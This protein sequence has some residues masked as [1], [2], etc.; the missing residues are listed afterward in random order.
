MEKGTKDVYGKILGHLEHDLLEILW[1]KGESN[2]KE[3]YAR[4]KD[5]R[6][7]ALTTVLTVLERLARKG[8]V[9]KVKGDSVYLFA[10]AYSKEE[11]A[12]RVSNEV[13]KG[14]FG[15][16]TAG[17]TASFVDILADIHPIELDRLSGLIAAKKK[18]LEK[19]AR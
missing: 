3:I 7:I 12:R 8:I 10:P 5:T 15:I 18:E 2:G 9:K 14:I 16:S 13:L 17:A 6:D 4:I 19:R 1:A 11:F